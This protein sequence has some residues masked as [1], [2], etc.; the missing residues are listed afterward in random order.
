MLLAEVDVLAESER[1]ADHHLVVRCQ[2]MGR[3]RF[4]RFELEGE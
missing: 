1:H 4:V 2:Q 3:G